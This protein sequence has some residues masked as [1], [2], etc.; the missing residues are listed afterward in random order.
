M[1]LKFEDFYLIV[2][3]GAMIKKRVGLLKSIRT[4]KKSASFLALFL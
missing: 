3:L 2:N 4:P 1:F